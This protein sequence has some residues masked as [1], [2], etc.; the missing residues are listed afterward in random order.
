MAV[1][2]SINRVDA[3]AKVTGRALYTEDLCDDNV[4]TAKVLH[5]T[6]ANGLVKSIDISEAEKIPGVVKIVTCFD[7]PD[8]KFG[9]AG[10]PYSLDPSHKDIEDRMLLNKRVRIYGDDIAAVVAVDDISAQR[11][12]KAIKV[13]YEVYKPIVS[14]KQAMAEGV[15]QLHEGYK[16][17][18]LVF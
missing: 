1:G 6:I 9:T 15:T 3:V 14:A 5:S 7:V 8:I 16:N 2:K 12:L 17:N 10:H 4:L 11:A 13:E 18:I